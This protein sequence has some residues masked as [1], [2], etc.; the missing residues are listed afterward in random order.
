MGKRSDLINDSKR[1]DFDECRKGS[2]LHLR[3]SLAASS[4][5]LAAAA[6]AVCVPWQIN[7]FPRG[8]F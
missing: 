4:L 6:C 3:S 7:L 8:H 2:S 1:A 5:L